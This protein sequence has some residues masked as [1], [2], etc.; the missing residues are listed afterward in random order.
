[1]RAAAAAGTAE[2]AEFLSIA[3]LVAELGG[4]GL[5][6]AIAGVDADPMIDMGLSG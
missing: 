3:Y 2:L 4:Y 5:E 6:M 1:M